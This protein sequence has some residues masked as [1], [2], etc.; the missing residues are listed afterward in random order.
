M[1]STVPHRGHIH[2]DSHE[3]KRFFKEW[4]AVRIRSVFLTT[5][6]CLL[7]ATASV[8]AA[9]VRLAWDANTE[10]DV[11]GYIVEYG[12][13][14]APF[15]QAVD[16]GNVTTWTLT[17]AVQGVIYGFRVIA[18]DAGGL[19]SDASTPVYATSD[20]PVGATLTADRQWLNFGV[21]GGNSSGADRCAVD[22][23]DAGRH[24][25]GDVDG[26]VLGALA[27]GF[28]GLG[29]GL[30]QHLGVTGAWRAARQR[31]R[32]DPHDLGDRRVQHHRSDSRH[33]QRDSGG[34]ERCARRRGR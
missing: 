4:A 28:T 19:R 31:Q 21:I 24:R 20:G 5:F 29:H 3:L 11:T 16:V 14:S 34:R 9:Q 10:P 6:A 30:R 23:P 33:H 32:R 25:D 2:C 18:Y 27:A 15:S 26:L 17:S 12:P 8:D 7:L 13:M 1:D 22:P